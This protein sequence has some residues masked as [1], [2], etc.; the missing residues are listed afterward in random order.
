LLYFCG[1]VEWH[2]PFSLADGTCKI[3]AIRHEMR[4][5]KSYRQAV[6]STIIL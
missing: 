2:K 6:A 5:V 3:K 4:R 1:G